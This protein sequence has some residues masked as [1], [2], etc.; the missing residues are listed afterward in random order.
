M[1]SK[2][3]KYIVRDFDVEIFLIIGRALFFTI[4]IPNVPGYGIS[5]I[6]RIKFEF[7]DERLYQ[8]LF[9]F[10]IDTINK[11]KGVLENY[12][13]LKQEVYN[14]ISSLGVSVKK[15]KNNKKISPMGH[16]IKILDIIESYIRQ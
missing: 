15:L 10:Y 16:A 4:K 1:R 12:Q 11:E 13:L 2:I 7:L 9:C 6:N 8:I 5:S 14:Y 3:A